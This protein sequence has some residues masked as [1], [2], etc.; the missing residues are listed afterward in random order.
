[1]RTMEQMSDDQQIAEEMR[2][3]RKEELAKVRFRPDMVATAWRSRPSEWMAETQGARDEPMRGWNK[4]VVYTGELTAAKRSR[5]FDAR[6][7][8]MCIG[9]GVHRRP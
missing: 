9:D 3:K 8:T 5:L 4:D 2:T 7:R 1:M 6:P